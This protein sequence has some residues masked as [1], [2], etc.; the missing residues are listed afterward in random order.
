MQNIVKSMLD[1][2]GAMMS[3]H[4]IPYHK[5][6]IVVAAVIALLFSLDRI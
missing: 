2:V 4:V 1:E 5:V 6:A 3:G